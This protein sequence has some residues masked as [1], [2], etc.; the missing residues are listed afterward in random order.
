M[1]NSELDLVR[2]GDIYSLMIEYLIKNDDWNGATQIANEMKKNLPAE[3][4][5]FYVP[6]GMFLK[7][8]IF[9]N[10]IQIIFQKKS[11]FEE[12]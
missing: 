11:I 2:R 7:I 3:N 8:N 1:L 5:I 4:L 12:F 6:E 9:Q 10:L